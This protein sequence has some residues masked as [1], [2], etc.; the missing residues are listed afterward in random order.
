M[1]KKRAFIIVVEDDGEGD[2]EWEWFEECVKLNATDSWDNCGWSAMDYVELDGLD[3]DSISQAVVQ[4]TFQLQDKI[5]K[6][7]AE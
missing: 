1:A 4:L 3:D 2:P 7:K 5:E 6:S